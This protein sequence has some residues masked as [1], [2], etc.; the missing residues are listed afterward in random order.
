MTEQFFEYDPAEALES[1]EAVEIFIADALETGNADYV[2][3]ALKVV[4]RVQGMAQEAESK[5]RFFNL[6]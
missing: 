1:P 2:A 4:A 3:K 5:E 6:P